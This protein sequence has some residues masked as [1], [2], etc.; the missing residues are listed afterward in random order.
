LNPTYVVLGIVRKLLSQ[1]TGINL[2]SFEDQ[3]GST[4]QAI[5]YHKK[6]KFSIGAHVE[7]TGRLIKQAN[8]FQIY[9]IKELN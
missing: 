8:N 4:L 7:I 1:E 5:Y 9:K 2:I 3:L 6:A